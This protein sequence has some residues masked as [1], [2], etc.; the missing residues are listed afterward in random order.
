MPKNNKNDVTKNGQ[1]SLS[2]RVQSPS[3]WSPSV[4]SSRV[5]ASNRP[6]SK[7]P[8]VQNSNVLASRVQAAESVTLTCRNTGIIDNTLFAYPILHL[9]VKTLAAQIIQHLTKYRIRNEL[10]NVYML[11]K[12]KKTVL[13]FYIASTQNTWPFRNLSH[14]KKSW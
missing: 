10:L 6:E 13:C 14:W 11:S 2:P 9:C 8:G 3:V 4:Q 1:N 7:R 5:K 12:V